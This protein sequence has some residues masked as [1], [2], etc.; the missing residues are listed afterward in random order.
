MIGLLKNKSQYYTEKYR[1][2]IFQFEMVFSTQEFL[3]FTQELIHFTQEILPLLPK[4]LRTPHS[5]NLNVPSDNKLW[6]G[7]LQGN[8]RIFGVF[9]RVHQFPF[10]VPPIYSTFQFPHFIS[11]HILIH[12]LCVIHQLILGLEK[13][14]IW[15]TTDV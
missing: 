15:L 5:R 14:F 3:L 13:Y 9:L 12:S 2:I 1:P 11:F 7:F 6:Q 10:F 8:V 4:K